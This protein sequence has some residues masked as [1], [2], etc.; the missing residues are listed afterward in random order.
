MKIAEKKV[1]ENMG[2]PMEVA[3]R[4]EI[5]IIGIISIEASNKCNV[6]YLRCRSAGVAINGVKKAVYTC[7]P[8][9]TLSREYIASIVGGGIGC[10]R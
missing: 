1:N 8:S 5:K 2:A 4:K 3:S 7:N 9:G 6:R 10:L